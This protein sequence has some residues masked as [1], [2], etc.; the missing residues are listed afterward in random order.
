MEEVQGESNEQ[1]ENQETTPMDEERKEVEEME[2]DS[3][4]ARVFLTDKGVEIF[5]KTPSKK[6]FICERGFKELVLPFKEEIERRGWEMLCKHLDLD[7][8]T[9]VKEFYANLGD[10]KNQTC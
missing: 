5:K 7:R 9:I 10:R 3:R 4:R 6:G 2:G 1:P 8:R